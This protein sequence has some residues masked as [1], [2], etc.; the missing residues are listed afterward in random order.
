MPP[1][2]NDNGKIVATG[3]NIEKRK[4]GMK[5]QISKGKFI[6]MVHFFIKISDK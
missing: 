6:L 2:G 1:I 4:Q 3:T 5:T